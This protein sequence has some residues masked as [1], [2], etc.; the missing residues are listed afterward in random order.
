MDVRAT[1]MGLLFVTMWSSA[2][3]SATIAVRDAPPFLLL[4]VRFLIS[5][6]GA[7]L[8]GYLMGQ[9]IRIR[10]SQWPAIV[11]FGVCQNA[12]YLGFY[13]FAMQ[14]VEASLAVIIASCLPLVVASASWA[15]FG[16]TLSRRAIF[17]LAL[18]FGGVLLVMAN[19]LSGEVDGRGVLLCVLGLLA[20]AT[21]TLVLRK[22]SS[23]GNVLMIVGLQMLC[24]SLVL[25]PMSLVLEDWVVNWTPSLIAA[26]TYTTLVPGLAA[27]VIWF[28]LVERIGPTRAS[29]FHYLNPFLGV[30]I[31]AI[32]LGERLSVLDI[33]GVGTI[34]LGIYAVQRARS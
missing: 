2:F 31:A 3:T 22:A 4:T 30:L 6:G 14:T 24:G 18:G 12:L 25:L 26:F 17:G 29:S 15:L 33:L 34:M 23:A 27:T 7:L 11:I 1:L 10:R 28:W 20:L 16:E 9:R 21:A 8:I 19:R 5:G 13:F 32:I